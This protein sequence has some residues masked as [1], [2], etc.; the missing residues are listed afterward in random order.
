MPQ[1]QLSG[2]GRVTNFGEERYEGTFD[3]TRRVEMELV[4]TNETN[5]TDWLSCCVG[6]CS[7]L[8]PCLLSSWGKTGVFDCACS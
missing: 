8:D 6:G 7:D 4:Y 2:R 1:S 5:K 3:I